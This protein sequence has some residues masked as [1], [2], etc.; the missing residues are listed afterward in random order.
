MAGELNARDATAAQR[1]DARRSSEGSALL[2][3]QLSN[4]FQ[5]YNIYLC[6]NYMNDEC[7]DNVEN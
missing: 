3:L 7:K 6:V 1:R 4:F 5:W 2:F